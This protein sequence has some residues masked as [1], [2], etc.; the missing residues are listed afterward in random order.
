MLGVASNGEFW[1]SRTLETI[2]VLEKDTKHVNFLEE[3]DEDDRAVRVKARQLVETLKKV[4]A[5]QQEAAKGAELLLSATVLQQ[6]NADEGDADAD[7]LE[8]RVD[9]YQTIALTLTVR[10]AC[11]EATTRMFASSTKRSK[12]PRKSSDDTDSE[13]AEPVDILVD[14]I[15]GFLE[16]ST[17]Y[18]RAAANHAFSL[19]SSAVQETTIDLILTVGFIGAFTEFTT[20]RSSSSKSNA[21]TPQN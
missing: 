6:Y 1:I 13:P 4:P 19:L 17:A 7:I 20:L 2:E 10:Q 9:L 18:L 5:D 14:S 11:I 16:Q 3:V 15:I 12:K 8:V 21:G